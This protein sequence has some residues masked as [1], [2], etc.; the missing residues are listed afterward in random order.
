MVGPSGETIQVTLVPQPGVDEDGPHRLLQAWT[1]DQPLG[2]VRVEA[3][4]GW[5]RVAV[6]AGAAAGAHAERRA[7]LRAL[8]QQA[9]T[10]RLDG[11]VLV[12]GTPL[13]LRHEA[14]LAGFTGPLRHDLAWDLRP[15][16]EREWAGLEGFVK[17]VATL[18]PGVEIL[19]DQGAGGWRSMV[20]HAS[21]GMAGME[22]LTF[23]DRD[24]DDSPLRL[25]VPVRED[26]MPECVALIADTALSV[27]RYFR[28]LV[29]KVRVFVD[30][31]AESRNS[32]WA[33][34]A[35]QTARDIHLTGGYV[36]VIEMEALVQHLQQRAEAAS[37]QAPRPASYQ[38]MVPFTRI[39]AVVAHE[40]WHQ[41]AFD[42]DSSRYSD[43]VAF[44]RAVGAYFG[45]ETLEHVMKGKEPGA[46]PEWQR[47][48]AR[49]ADEVSTYATTNPQ[50]ASAELFSQ[51]WCTRA[52][53]PPS[54]QA[55]GQIL[56]HTFPDAGLRP[57][58]R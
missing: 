50:E 56:R 16:F 38:G 44:R 31:P 41:V 19:S 2:W 22:R 33:G 6:D 51:W 48:F 58:E 47:A 30:R 46:P 21:S 20:R 42:L 28:P 27:R 36:S 49:L 37:G 10:E 35:D 52:A 26:S 15:P 45:V 8:G 43:S 14:R 12:A 7:L 40:F 4:S 53:P 24:E 57:S 5:L 17:E 25:S 9:R 39:D 55:F 54:A 18:L 1:G 32:N 11:V 23:R 13:L 3:S 34:L 29:D